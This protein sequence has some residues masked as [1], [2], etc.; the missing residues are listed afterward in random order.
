MVPIIFR[1]KVESASMCKLRKVPSDVSDKI[2]LEATSLT[3]ENARMMKT[4]EV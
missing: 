1:C 2:G 3:S 4:R